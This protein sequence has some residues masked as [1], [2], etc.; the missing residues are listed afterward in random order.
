MTDPTPEA[1]REAMAWLKR[2]S[3][4]DP[5]LMVISALLAQ[6]RLPMTL[7]GELVEEIWLAVA[8]HQYKPHRETA[9][10]IINAIRAH[11]TKPCMKTTWYVRTKQS[12]SGWREYTDEVTMRMAVDTLLKQDYGLEIERGETPI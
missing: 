7:S 9:E 1:V 4:H 6:P 10:N 2:N 11:V 8:A 5:H 3:L 12:G